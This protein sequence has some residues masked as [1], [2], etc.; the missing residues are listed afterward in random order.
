M[1]LNL[2]NHPSSTWSEEQKDAALKQFGGIL[3]FPFPII[4]PTASLC[5]IKKLVSQTLDRIIL[6][7][8]PDLTIHIMGEFSFCYHMIKSFEQKG[9]RCFASTTVREPKFTFVMFRPYF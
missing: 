9:I 6:L 7:H 2:T 1:L 8:I 4:E 3:D 5:E